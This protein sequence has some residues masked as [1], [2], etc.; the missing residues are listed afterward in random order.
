MAEK[1]DWKAGRVI[2]AAYLEADQSPCI[3]DESNLA[4]AFLA[5]D[6][7]VEEMAQVIEDLKMNGID[8]GPPLRN[9]TKPEL[10]RTQAM[11]RGN[12]LIARAKE[13]RG[14]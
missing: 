5:L 2:A 6:A 11:K 4:R 14:G 7:L 1:I 9:L 12:A 3:D 8:E 10:R 13:T